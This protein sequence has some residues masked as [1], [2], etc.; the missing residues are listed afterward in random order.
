MKG[1]KTLPK[2]NT[3]T[4][5]ELL[6]TNFAVLNLG[7]ELFADTMREKKVEVVHVDW[8]PETEADQDEFADILK[9][10]L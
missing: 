8:Q 2:K 1:L 3:D 9:D 4:I 10:L 7:L 5:L 6:N